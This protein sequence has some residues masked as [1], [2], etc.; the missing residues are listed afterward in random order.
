MSIPHSVWKKSHVTLYGVVSDRAASSLGK[1][2]LEVAF[3]E[4]GNYRK[5]LIDFEIVD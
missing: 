4:K 5:E 3:G 2:K 1:I